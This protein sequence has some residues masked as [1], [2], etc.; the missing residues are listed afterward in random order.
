MGHRTHFLVHR[1]MAGSG[2]DA[3]VEGRRMGPA[4]LLGRALMQR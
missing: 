4:L 1:G 3:G 2:S